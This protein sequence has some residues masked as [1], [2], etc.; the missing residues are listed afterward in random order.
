MANFKTHLQFATVSCGGASTLLMSTSTI[1]ATDAMLYWVA[2]TVG[3]LLPD[4]DSDNSHSLSIV[5]GILSM[6]GCVTCVLL[7]I[8]TWPITWVWLGCLVTFITINLPLRWVF[9]Q[10]TV[11]RGVFHSLL[12][13]AVVA[14]GAG[15]IGYRLG[16]ASVQAWWLIS[17]IGFGYVL[18]LVLDEL[19]SVDFSNA[20]IKRSFGSALKLFDYQNRVTCAALTLVLA[21]LIYFA[22]PQ[23]SYLEQ[24]NHTQLLSKITYAIK[25]GW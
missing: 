24:I 5:F 21:G 1:S 9:E 25:Q 4:A 6:L 19:Y 7:T 22:P 16:L 10:F 23:Y 17:F 8:N 18:H 14:L 2:G 3:G 20:A 13:G 15:L 12:A 11:H